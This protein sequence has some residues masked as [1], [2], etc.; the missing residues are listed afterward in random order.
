MGD[1]TKIEWTDATWNPIIGCSRV[2]EGCRNCYAEK[3]AGRFGNGKPT[4]Y[5]GLT[6]IVNGRSVWVIV[7]GESGPGARPMHPEWARF[8]RDQ[9]ASAGVPYFFKQWGNWQPL[10][11]IEGNS[12]DWKQ[13]RTQ[14]QCVQLDGT[15]FNR[16]LLEDP[17]E[18]A[19]WMER[20]SKK[21][22][23]A[24]LDGVEHKAFPGVR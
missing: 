7:G 10:R 8:L 12:K 13:V 23:G 16:L 5:S 15:H 24:L 14:G 4:V 22:A 11:K 18:S 6:Q 21:A 2:S 19:Q 20:V 1:N 3:I 9:C 17:P